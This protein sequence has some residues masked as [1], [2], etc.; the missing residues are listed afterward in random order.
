M[1]REKMTTIEIIKN[2]ETDELFKKIIVE[3]E[4]LG[5]E[6]FLEDVEDEELG[7]ECF[8]LDEN[9]KWVAYEEIILNTYDGTP[10]FDTSKFIT[11]SRVP[12]RVN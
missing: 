11:L 1:K 10:E 5:I 9:N 4:A 12:S 6:A 3:R 8:K 2:I 7:I